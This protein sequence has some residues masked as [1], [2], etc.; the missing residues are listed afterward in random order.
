MGQNL[1]KTMVE[2]IVYEVVLLLLLFSQ[3]VP[4][5]ASASGSEKHGFAESLKA[6]AAYC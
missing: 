3:C 2:S 5:H 6:T 1:T 4:L